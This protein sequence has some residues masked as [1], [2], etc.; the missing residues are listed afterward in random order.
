M[1]QLLGRAG[2]DQLAA[3]LACPRAEIHDVIGSGDDVPVMFDDDHRIALVG[4]L[5]QNGHQPLGITRV[6][7]D[8]G[9]IQD[10]ERVRQP[11][12][13]LVRQVDALGFA[14]RKRAGETVDGEI[15]Q[16]HMAQETQPPLELGS[17][18]LGDLALERREL[19]RGE[20]LPRA[21][22]R[23]Y[24]LSSQ[25]S[26]FDFHVQHILAQPGTCT[27]G[28]IDGGDI[29]AQKDADVQLIFL[30]LQALKEG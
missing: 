28:T 20:K 3:M 1:P 11:G 16:P 15:V 18:T 12:T 19:N 24:R 8:C 13:Q 22:P 14:A 30:C 7:S 27:L 26:C 5:P 29:A 25:S 10:I 2:E 4:E 9:L 17:D 6:Q 21:L 23:S